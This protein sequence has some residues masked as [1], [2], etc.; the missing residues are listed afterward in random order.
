MASLDW[1][2]MADEHSIMKNFLSDSLWAW[3][4][5]N[6][7]E[8]D[9]ECK[10][11]YEQQMGNSHLST[12]LA[13]PALPM[14]NPLPPLSLPN[15]LPLPAVNATLK[16]LFAEIK[17]YKDVEKERKLGVPPKNSRRYKVLFSLVGSMKATSYQVNWRRHG[18][19]SQLS[20]N[21][22]QHWLTRFI[23]E[24][25]KQNGSV[26]TPGSLHHITA[27]LMKHLCWNRRSEIDL[28]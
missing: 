18:S 27:G 24:I 11:I 12:P 13:S 28:F 7:D 23:L 17:T 3:Y 22:I 4:K 8:N 1:T 25:R 2:D 6:S 14:T 19:P 15:P 9:D 16:C 10:N 5:S 21:N 26:F 20:A